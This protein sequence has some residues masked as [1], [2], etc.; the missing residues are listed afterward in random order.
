MLMVPRLLLERVVTVELRDI[1]VNPARPAIQVAQ[2]PPERPVLRARVA[3][4][5]RVGPQDIPVNREPLA[6]QGTAVRAE[7]AAIRVRV[8]V[9]RAGIRALENPG[10]ADT[11]GSLARVGTREFQAR[12]AIQA[13]VALQA[14]VVRRDTQARVARRDTQV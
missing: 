6:R 2:A 12:V 10:R 3:T 8:S 13:K 7:P 9:E 1:V 14:T 11:R 4:V 5:V